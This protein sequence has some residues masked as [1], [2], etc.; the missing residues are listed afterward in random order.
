MNI[1]AGTILANVGVISEEDCSDG[2]VMPS[3]LNILIILIF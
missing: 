2:Q 1:S 3:Y